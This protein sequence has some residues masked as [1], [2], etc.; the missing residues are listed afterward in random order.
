M[1]H[2]VIK[3]VFGFFGHRRLYSA[4]SAARTRKNIE[5]SDDTSCVV[6]V[7]DVCLFSMVHWVDQQYVTVT[8]SG[9]TKLQMYFAETNGGMTCDS[10]NEAF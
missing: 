3:L 4:Y 9:H 7:C 2:H 1:G 10:N 5:N 6:A 8:C